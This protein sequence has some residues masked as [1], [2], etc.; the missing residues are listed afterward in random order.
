MLDFVMP[1][2]NML[3]YEK[4]NQNPTNKSISNKRTNKQ[5]KPNKQ[6]NKQQKNQQANE[7]KIDTSKMTT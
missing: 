2:T 6:I 7:E 4:N 1:W 3:C 5:Q